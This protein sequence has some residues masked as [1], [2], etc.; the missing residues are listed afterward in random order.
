MT[1][2]GIADLALCVLGSLVLVAVIE[3]DK[4]RRRRPIS[5]TP[6]EVF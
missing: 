1:A 5:P 4:A 2:L 6:L 3:V